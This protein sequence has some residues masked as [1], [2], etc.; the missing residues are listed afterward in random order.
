MISVETALAQILATAAPLAPERVELLDAEGR[1]AALSVTARYA[2]PSFDNSAMDGYAVRVADGATPRRVIGTVACGDAPGALCVNPG[3]TARIMTGAPLPPGADAVIMQEEASRD[4][5]TCSFSRAP[6]LGQHVRRLGSDVAVGDAILSP[7]EFLSPAAISTLAAQG[8][9]GVVVHR[10]PLVAILSTGSELVE[11]DEAPGPGQL[12][13]SNSYAL[14][15]LVK[16]AGGVPVLLGIAR[17][18]RAET[19]T[20]LSRALFADV[21]LTSGGVSVGEFDYVKECLDAL[22]YQPGFWKVAMKPGKPVVFGTLH[23]KPVLGL[24]GNPASCQVSFELFA[25]PLLRRLLGDPNPVR[26]R[27]RVTLRA[28]LSSGERR[29]FVRAVVSV[30]ADGSLSALPMRKQGSSDLRSML[31]AN[32]VLD[33][34]PQVE[35]GAGDTIHAIL[36]EALKAAE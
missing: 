13:N 5:D 10:R 28:P 14:A 25:R 24:P 7:G 17:D 2:L 6:S 27:V 32:A 3:E 26:P 34:P 20:L 31:G 30:A 1:F 15:A 9:A 19:E 35:L 18:D 11:L 4:G 36:F 16:A 12:V 23:G 29:N 8:K 33:V 21:L 22:G